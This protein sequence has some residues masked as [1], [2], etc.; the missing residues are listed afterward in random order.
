[1]AEATTGVLNKQNLA[2]ASIGAK[3]SAVFEVIM[4]LA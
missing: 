1:M 4:I 3:F 2:G